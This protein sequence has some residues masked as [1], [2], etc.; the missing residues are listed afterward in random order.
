MLALDD[1]TLDIEPGITGSWAPTAQARLPRPSRLRDLRVADVCRP[2]RCRPRPRRRRRPLEG[3]DRQRAPACRRLWR[4]RHRREPAGLLGSSRRLR[5]GARRTAAASTSSAKSKSGSRPTTSDA[6]GTSRNA[7]LAESL[8]APTSQSRPEPG[9]G[10]PVVRRTENG[11]HV[12]TVRIEEVSTVVV[13][14]VLPRTGRT[15]AFEPRLDPN[16]MKRPHRGL[17]LRD[18]RDVKRQAANGCRLWRQHSPSHEGRDRQVLV[19]ARH[20]CDASAV[21]RRR[22]PMTT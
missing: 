3:L 8:A 6:Q 14:G 16:A 17:R 4:H 18:E 7:G 9:P 13:G 15:A 11:F 10:G 22:R 12:V 2:R 19:T 1:L 5:L 21:R 20:A